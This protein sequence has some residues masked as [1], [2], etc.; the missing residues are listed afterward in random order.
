MEY[1]NTRVSRYYLSVFGERLQFFSLENSEILQELC[2]D[3]RERY[4]VGNLGWKARKEIC[5]FE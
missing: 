1:F 5:T 4:D 3:A 2:A